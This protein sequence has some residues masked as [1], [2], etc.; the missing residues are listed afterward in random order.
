MEEDSLKDSY[1][2]QNYEDIKA[3]LKNFKNSL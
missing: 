2:E 1:E 3:I